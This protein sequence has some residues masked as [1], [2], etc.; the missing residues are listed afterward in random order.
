M[1]QRPTLRSGRLAVPCLLASAVFPSTSRAQVPVFTVT[2]EE[3]E[4]KFFEGLGGHRPTPSQLYSTSRFM[5]TPLTPGA[6]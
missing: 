1:S 2:P 6:A 5:Q 4:V 3:S